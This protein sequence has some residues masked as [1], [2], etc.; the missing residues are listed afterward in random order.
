VAKKKKKKKKTPTVSDSQD[1]S[2]HYGLFISLAS[3]PKN[4]L[5]LIKVVNGV[6]VG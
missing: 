3:N 6:V 5:N 2:N 1:Q 4:R